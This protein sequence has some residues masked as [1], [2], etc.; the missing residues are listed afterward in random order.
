M[1]NP[2]GYPVFR[3][4]D[5]VQA[6]RVARQLVAAGDVRY[7]QV[8]VDVELHRPGRFADTRSA[9][10]C[11]VRKEDGEDWTRDASD[12]TGLHVGVHAPG[13][14]SDPG[15]LSIPYPTRTAGC[16]DAGIA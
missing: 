5:P 7:A 15:F 6:L 13:L 2:I 9:A 4:A 14:S 8:S 12:P 10:G 3:T 16:H 1:S 11:L